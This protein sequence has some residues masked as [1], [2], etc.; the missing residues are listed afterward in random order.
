MRTEPGP[1]Q[2]LS[3]SSKGPSAAVASQRRGGAGWGRRRRR[4]ARG[5]RPRGRP[6]PRRASRCRRSVLRRYRLVASTRVRDHLGAARALGRVRGHRPGNRERVQVRILGARTSRD[7]MSRRAE[8][9]RTTT[10]GERSRDARER[11]VPRVRDAASGATSARRALA[12]WER[13]GGTTG[14]L[15]SRVVVRE[16]TARFVSWFRSTGDVETEE[17]K[18][19]FKHRQGRNPFCD[20]N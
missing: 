7:A 9:Y 14:V 10:F 13:R 3:E 11:S 1:P 15:P 16:S 2:S 19:G 4:A 5:W 20:Q 6:A 18:F 12:A 17:I 8:G